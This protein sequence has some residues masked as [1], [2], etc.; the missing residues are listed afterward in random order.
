MR[1]AGSGM[2]EEKSEGIWWME[3][4]WVKRDAI[5]WCE[6]EEEWAKMGLRKKL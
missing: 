5:K 1:V 6:R 2:K 4:E 3:G